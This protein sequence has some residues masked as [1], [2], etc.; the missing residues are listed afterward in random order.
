MKKFKK[1]LLFLSVV[2]FTSLPVVACTVKYNDPNAKDNKDQKTDKSELQP[3]NQLIERKLFIEKLNNLNLNK[4][5]KNEII[6]NTPIPFVN[7]NQ[8]DILL[9]INKFLTIEAFVP[10]SFKFKYVKGENLKEKIT[11]QIHLISNKIKTPLLFNQPLV[12]N[13]LINEADSLINK[14]NNL[15]KSKNQ[16]FVFLLD[17]L[18]QISSNDI[19]IKQ[20]GLFLIQ[21]HLN[22]YDEVDIGLFTDLI[23][24]KNNFSY[25]KTLLSTY[26]NLNDLN[27]QPIRDYVH[28]L[29]NINS[30]PELDLIKLIE[31]SKSLINKTKGFFINNQNLVVINSELKNKTTQRI[32]EFFSDDITNKTKWLTMVEVS[33][34]DNDLININNQLDRL[35][36]DFI[37]RQT[38]LKN[39]LLNTPFTTNIKNLIN[40]YIYQFNT[41][42]QLQK[43]E[44]S[45]NNFNNALKIFIEKITKFRGDIENNNV[46]SINV[47]NFYKFLSR[48]RNIFTNNK[49][50][51]LPSLDF[52]HIHKLI[53]SMSKE[54]N[55]IMSSQ[56]QSDLTLRE[57]L[58]K[59]T[60]NL[61]HLDYGINGQK[62][63]FDEYATPASFNLTN[64]NI[65]FDNY[66]TDIFDFS[67]TDLEWDLANP[68]VLIATITV[69]IKGV[70]NIQV[71]FKKTKTFSKT[72]DLDI[73]RKQEYQYLDDLFHIDYA[74]IKSSQF[75][76]FDQ[77]EH[78][79]DFFTPLY[80]GI[81]QYFNYQINHVEFVNNH[82]YVHVGVYWNKQLIKSFV[83]QPKNKIYFNTELPN[84]VFLD[85]LHQI[86][87]EKI[88]LNT[89]K[90]RVV[91]SQLFYQNLKL[92]N[93]NQALT[94]SDFTINQAQKAINEVYDL[95]KFG[96]YQV[97]VKE[98]IQHSLTSKSVKLVLWYTY[99]GVEVPNY[100]PNKQRANFIW[101]HNFKSF[102]WFDI[103]PKNKHFTQAD[104]NSEY[105]QP[106]P[107]EIIN[108]NKINATNFD[109]RYTEAI[110]LNRAKN[111]YVGY[112]SLNPQKLINQEAFININY[113]L[114][115]VE[116]RKPETVT[117]PATI[118]MP[119]SNNT[120]APLNTPINNANP[121]IINDNY[122]LFFYDV[123]LVN[124]YSMSFKLGYINK[125]NH[126]IRYTNNKDIT[127]VNL[128]NDYEQAL[129]PEIMLNNITYD[130]L[131]FD[132]QLIHNDL[133]YYTTYERYNDLKK[134]IR[135]RANDQD[136]I[137]YQNFS[138][139]RNYFEINAFRVVNNKL[140]FNLK[141]TGY[142]TRLN[143]T[144]SIVGKNWYEVPK[145]RLANHNPKEEW[146]TDQQNLLTIYQANHSVYRQRIIEPYW[147]DLKWT[148]NNETNS[149]Q[150][151]LPL[152]YLEQTLL[153]PN[154]KNPRINISFEANSL[155][156]DDLK[157]NRF[158]DEQ[159]Q[160]KVSINWNELIQKQI[161]FQTYN[162]PTD[163]T[164]TYQI[165]L[166]M[167]YDPHIGITFTF[168]P[169]NPK[170]KILVDNPHKFINE[171]NNS[172]F[173]ENKA[174]LITDYAAKISISYTNY[175]QNENFG[176]ES[177]RF[178]YND[179]YFSKINQPTL[180]ANDES[181]YTNK[182][183]YNPNQ[184]VYWKLHDG[185]KLDVDT[186]RLD[187][188]IKFN[189]AHNEYIRA[190]LN[191]R[192]YGDQIVYGSATILARVSTN[193]NDKRF[194]VI[195]NRHVEGDGLDNYAS[196]AH[197]NFLREFTN[198]LYSTIDKYLKNDLID[199]N[200]Q[201]FWPANTYNGVNIKVIY[202]GFEQNNN[203][204]TYISNPDITV[205]V[206]DL[207]PFYQDA[208]L[209]GYTDIIYKIDQLSNKDMQLDISGNDAIINVP[210]LREATVLGF[211]GKKQTGLI[212]N[213]V[214][215]DNKNIYINT[216]N[217]Y[218][219]VFAAPG[220]SGTG[221]ILDNNTYFG[222]IKSQWTTGTKT[223]GLHY[224][225]YL[226]NHFG[227]N[228]NHQNPLTLVNDKSLGAQILRANLLDPINYRLPW[229]FKKIEQNQQ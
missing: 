99:K 185:F 217:H 56:K 91:Q 13:D 44:N 221:F 196:V 149:A 199:G 57:L 93:P 168:F 157:N 128:V 7:T 110:L 204:D 51:H 218:P 68:Q 97:I 200:T 163:T 158:F 175:L 86:A 66:D 147:R 197:K 141:V 118:Y 96:N 34:L 74:R 109:W 155:I 94:H 212:L 198:R 72:V 14:Y 202:S 78:Y 226:Y 133:N 187:K 32:L 54:L 211:P 29:E 156:M 100:D 108:F 209:H 148:K 41:F 89:T 2:L 210:H 190:L 130:D 47:Y 106:N 135:I 162:L 113:F 188:Y 151:L 24:F 169:T 8:A 40:T 122:Y 42:K 161:L 10:M 111:R 213:R 75:D 1:S 6:N 183:I 85:K 216:H 64:A 36:S 104:F 69:A 137:V 229:F 154:L 9:I 178:D 38:T 192:D 63:N 39:T 174:F 219:T 83:L 195:T 35:T 37:H 164:V 65:F 16:Q 102:N 194:Y 28:N 87:I 150:W 215:T 114:N 165:L 120:L 61:Y 146:N 173:D 60:E 180:F 112:R 179:V 131:I 107:D 143:K 136:Q 12:I 186:L 184:N 49:I 71:S 67:I 15:L 5:I 160:L 46:S 77:R 22:N 116:S 82:L 80:T 153:Q 206:V 73:I 4:E 92:K 59:E 127:L 123:R 33:I 20:I 17:S 88:V 224:A 223:W 70:D 48:I 126:N 26:E 18:N 43:F 166:I 3:N 207:N 225:G 124:R 90:N 21:Q 159:Y 50:V 84:D 31:T 145:I 121:Q 58:L 81:K 132:D 172:L 177:N 19:L 105:Q 53:V 142:N 115:L 181:F 138:L 25:L 182:G 52:N 144:T 117:D 125:N 27:L 103:K 214:P 95:P 98:I 30:V 176:Y 140:Y 79:E 101:M 227:V 55:I 76:W 171:N 129:Y 11:N 193:P 222:L 45:F 201:G 189:Q 170:Y 119:L 23:H 62:F 228:F 208:L 152:K 191:V 134:A 203:S 139:P 205:F 167:K 220:M